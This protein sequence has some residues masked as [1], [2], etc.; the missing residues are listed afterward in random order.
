MKKL[1]IA[2]FF[3]IFIWVNAAFSHYQTRNANNVDTE[4]MQRYVEH[5]NAT[6]QLNSYER[7]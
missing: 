2:I 6:G 7:K 4:R 3:I 5:I 1:C